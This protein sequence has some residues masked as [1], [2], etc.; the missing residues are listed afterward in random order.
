MEP[1]WENKNES[2]KRPTEEIVPTKTAGEPVKPKAVKPLKFNGGLK[3]SKIK[4][5]RLHRARHVV[6]PVRIVIF[7]RRLLRE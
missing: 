4:S 3:S 2:D 1:T 6:R 7:T 5:T